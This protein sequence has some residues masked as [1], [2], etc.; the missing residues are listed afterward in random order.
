MKSSK[1]L[2]FKE[3]CINCLETEEGIFMLYVAFIFFFLRM[4]R[5]LVFEKQVNS[6]SSLEWMNEWKYSVNV[7]E[8]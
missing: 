6:V 5:K 1:W 4:R 3:P 7:A 2:E 8:A